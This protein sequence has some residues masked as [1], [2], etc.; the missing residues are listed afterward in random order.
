MQANLPCTINDSC[1]G[2]FL[3]KGRKLNIFTFRLKFQSFQ[4]HCTLL[5]LPLQT[6]F[7]HSSLQ[8]QSRKDYILL[9][10]LIIICKIVF[11]WG[12]IIVPQPNLPC[13]IND[14][15]AGKFQVQMSYHL[16]LIGSQAN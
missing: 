9:L 16:L 10:S 11:E 15:G 8:C 4:D 13:T 5:N 2:K 12:K 14:S 1:A 6:Y 7:F 3:T